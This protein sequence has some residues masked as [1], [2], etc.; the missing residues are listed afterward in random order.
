MAIETLLPN[1]DDSGWPSGTFEDINNGIATPSGTPMTTTV[2]D[3]VLLI[4]FADAVI[5]KDGDIVNS[6]TVKILG[7]TNG[8]GNDMHLVDLLISSVGQG[9]VTGASLGGTDALEDFT[10]AAWDA[11]HSVADINSFQVQVTANQQGMPA[12]VGHEIEE[13]AIEIDFTPEIELM[14]QAWL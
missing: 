7:R 1:A 9:S 10:N 2:T 3:D 5:I 6:V 13:M 12:T 11:D 4:S 8:S 14:A